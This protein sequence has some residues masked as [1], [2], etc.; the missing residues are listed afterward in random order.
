MTWPEEFSRTIPRRPE[1]PL[2]QARP[3]MVTATGIVFEDRNTN[4]KR[5]AGEPGLPGVRGQ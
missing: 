1:P 3:R 4:G 2:R 5:D